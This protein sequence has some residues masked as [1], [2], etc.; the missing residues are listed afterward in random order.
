MLL[1]I[2]ELFIKNSFQHEFKKKCF[3][4]YQSIFHWDE[5]YFYSPW[6]REKP[7]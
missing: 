2:H 7:R 1:N 5:I 4:N 3:D 6:P